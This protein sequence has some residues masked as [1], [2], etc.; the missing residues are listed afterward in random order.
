[1]CDVICAVGDD[2]RAG[3][4]FSTFYF[5]FSLICLQKSADNSITKIYDFD[6]GKKKK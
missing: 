6:L 5:F 2:A 4:A 3:V 1:M